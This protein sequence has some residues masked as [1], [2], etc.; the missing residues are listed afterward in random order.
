MIEV[1]IN[2]DMLQNHQHNIMHSIMMMTTLREAGMPIL[3]KIIF[4]GPKYGTLVMHTEEDMDGDELVVRWY[5]VSESQ[6]PGRKL[7]LVA[8]GRGPG[9]TWRRFAAPG[10]APLKTAGDEW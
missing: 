8:D 9:Y 10:D 6:E 4:N 2:S 5:N 1:R 7:D 3:G